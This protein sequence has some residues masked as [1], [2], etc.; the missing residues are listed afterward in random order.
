M[1]IFC[2]ILHTPYSQQY[3]KYYMVFK[4]L[5]AGYTALKSALQKSR[6]FFAQK[7]STLFATKVDEEL[8]DG[9]EELFFEADLGLPTAQDLIKKTRKFLKEKPQATPIEI[10]AFLQEELTNV[11]L[12]ANSSL[13]S[14]ETASTPAVILI[15]GVN[16]NG[17]TT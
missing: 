11:L 2:I 14:P 6:S 16:G 5:K 13:Y 15:V 1:R 7:L 17:K 9:L 3:K 4:F 10:I 8:I 12:S